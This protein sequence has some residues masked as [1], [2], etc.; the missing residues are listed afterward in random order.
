[1]NKDKITKIVEKKITDIA[2]VQY[3]TSI[4]PDEVENQVS[5]YL[6]SNIFFKDPW[7]EGSGKEKYLLG[8]KGFH[9][10]FYFDLTL[11]QANVILDEN[12]KKGR[13]IIDCNMNLRQLAWIYTYPLRTILVYTFEITHIDHEKEEVKFQIL[14][15]EEMWSFGDLLE[16]IP[17]FGTFYTKVFRRLFAIGFLSASF[18]SY[19]IYNYFHPDNTSVSSNRK[20]TIPFAK[21]D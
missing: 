13:A 5:D 11:F 21:S 8:Q 4:S 6:S 10:M 19:K 1:M 9:C 14:E 18:I 16:N 3:D 20:L 15:H 7:Q 12:M 17:F 2:I